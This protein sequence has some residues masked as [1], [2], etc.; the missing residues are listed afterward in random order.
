M[1]RAIRLKRASLDFNATAPSGRNA[2]SDP[3]NALMAVA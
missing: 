2:G 1:Q 3:A